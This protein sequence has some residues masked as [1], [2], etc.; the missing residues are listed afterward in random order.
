P[1]IRKEIFTLNNPCS[2]PK[3]LAFQDP[4]EALD[5]GN[6]GGGTFHK[7]L[8]SI[9]IRWMVGRCNHDPDR[10]P[11]KTSGKG[12]R[13][14]DTIPASTILRPVFRRP[15][16]KDRCRFSLECRASRPTITLMFR[17]DSPLIS[18][19]SDHPIC[20][21]CG[22]PSGLRYVPRI[23]QEFKISTGT[24]VIRSP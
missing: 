12:S 2:F 20:S 11:G 3:N 9:V 17:W 21:A 4:V 24:V 19:P 1:V 8:E 10:R 13:G 5:P 14:D 6:R 7:K 23:S 16:I 22:L 15:W 18:V